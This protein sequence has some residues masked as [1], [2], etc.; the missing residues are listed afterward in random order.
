MSLATASSSREGIGRYLKELR[1]ISDEIVSEGGR[2]DLTDVYIHDAVIDL[3]LRDANL[4]NAGFTNVEFVDCDMSGADL[5]D[6]AMKRCLF[7]GATMNHATT[8]GMKMDKVM[9]RG[10]EVTKD[11]LSKPEIRLAIKSN[12]VI[13][14]KFGLNRFALTEPQPGFNY[15][16]DQESMSHIAVKMDRSGK[17]NKREIR[18]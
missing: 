1:N 2:V 4:E 5:T 10:L 7:V 11:D 12:D 16:Y 8:D 14:T 17:E 13:V 6:V 3:N 18:S 15:K 9:F